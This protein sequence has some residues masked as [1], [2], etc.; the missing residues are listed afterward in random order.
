M[1]MKIVAA[2]AWRNWTEL[3]HYMGDFQARLLLTLLYFTWLLPFGL[4]LR[5]FGDPLDIR[6]APP[7]STGWKK[8]AVQQ[9]D[10]QALR[11]QF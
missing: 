2:R 6:R 8:R 3:T 10:L 11:R 7:E 9:R 5:L 1:F 4:L